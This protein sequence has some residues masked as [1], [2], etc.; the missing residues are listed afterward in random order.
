MDLKQILSKYKII[1]LGFVILFVFYIVLFYK[2]AFCLHFDIPAMFL[3]L[4]LRDPDAHFTTYNIFADIKIRL[5]TNFIVAIPFNITTLFYKFNNLL[6]YLRLFATSYLIVQFTGLILNFVI[7]KRTKRYD[8]A[9]WAFFLYTFFTLP[10]MIWPVRELHIAVLFYFMILSYFLSR[11][12][13]NKIDL[14]PV[15]LLLIYLFESFETSIFFGIIL[16][17]F[18]YLMTTKKENTTNSWIKTLIGTGGLLSSIYVVLKLIYLQFMQ[19]ISA[20]GLG[21]WINGSLCAFQN[22]LNGNFIITIS[23]LIL[24]VACIFYK[25]S[26]TWKSSV[27]FIPFISF[28]GYILYNKTGFFPDPNFE[29][30]YYS[31]LL[32]VLY[33]VV[34]LICYLDYKDIDI[35]KF[36]KNFLGNLFLLSCICGI[37]NLCWQINTCHNYEKYFLYLKNLVRNSKETITHIPPEDFKY[38]NFLRFNTCYGII[39]KSLFLSDTKEI[40]TLMF[41]PEDT[42]DYWCCA[43]DEYN[44]YDKEIDAIFMHGTRVKLISDYYDLTPIKEYY[45]KHG[46]VKNN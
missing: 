39:H 30:N 26:L 3:G 29:L 22:L 41:P 4:L 17:V 35:N 32:W 38:F 10:A 40:K 1:F 21:T 12:K 9:V 2:S 6:D 31:P 5:F 45:E 42:S 16:F 15:S 28:L 20:A 11:E 43:G 36:N 8:I 7:A 27:F 13:L 18:A 37:L 24:A 25:K 33:P 23:F 46:K 14:I 34:F 44:Y 19:N